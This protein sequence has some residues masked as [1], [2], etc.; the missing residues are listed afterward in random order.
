[1][2]KKEDSYIRLLKQLREEM[3][4][5]KEGRNIDDFKTL[6]KENYSEIKQDPQFLFND[7][8]K[9][10]DFDKT[11]L[12]IGLNSYFM[13]MQYEEMMEARREALEAVKWARWA[14]YISIAA[15]IAQI[16]F[17]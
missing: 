15:I 16:F 8:F 10:K 14:L 1:M 11:K 7:I 13:L 12:Y 6:L 4:A 9:G 17:G 5:N 2:K 3:R